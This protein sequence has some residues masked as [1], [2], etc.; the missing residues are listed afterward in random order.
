M[1]RFEGDIEGLFE[2][3]H[4]FLLLVVH[5]VPNLVLPF[6]FDIPSTSILFCSR[7]DARLYFVTRLFQSVIFFW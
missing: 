4:S 2:S 7:F 5:L 6:R 1:E 3:R